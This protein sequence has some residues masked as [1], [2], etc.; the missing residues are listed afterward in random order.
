MSM[1]LWPQQKPAFEK[2]LRSKRERRF[3]GLYLVLSSALTTGSMVPNNEGQE[4]ETE[5][6]A[7]LKGTLG[8]F[9]QRILFWGFFVKKNWLSEIVETLPDL[10]TTRHS[11]FY[12]A[13]SIFA[14]LRN[15]VWE[16]WFEVDVAFFRLEKSGW[17]EKKIWVCR[18]TF[19]EPLFYTFLD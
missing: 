5:D 7:G 1:K 6:G 4:S 13:P 9:D 3:L 19:L 8:D 10:E 12:S 18:T 15:L 17:P 16:I 11:P 14:V 2:I